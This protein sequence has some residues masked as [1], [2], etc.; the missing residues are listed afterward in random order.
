MKQNKLKKISIWTAIITFIL[1]TLLLI[2]LYYSVIIK[3]D[4]KF[5]FYMMIIAMINF[6]ILFILG[7]IYKNKP[8]NFKIYL[9]ASIYIL[10]N[11][12]VA[13]IYLYLALSLSNIMRINLINETGSPI[14]NV[15]VHSNGTITIENLNIRE[16]DRV[17]VP[18]GESTGIVITYEI[19][20]VKYNEAIF[21]FVT[22]GMGIMVSYRVGIDSTNNYFI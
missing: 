6:L 12:P 10:L 13:I 17:F 15:E 5:Y 18:L 2:A 9:K 4:F 7:V 22:S 3:N 1:E 21:D 16:C 8:K 20:G 14:T 11:I 19:N